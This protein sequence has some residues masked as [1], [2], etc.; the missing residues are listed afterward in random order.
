MLLGVRRAR[1]AM[2]GVGF[3]VK[4]RRKL[5]QVAE[6]LLALAHHRLGLLPLHKLA[7]LAGNDSDR[8]HQALVGRAHV[9]RVKRQD[10]DDAPIG[11]H[12]A[13]ER[14]SRAHVLRESRARIGLCVGH[15]ERLA[16]L[17]C[18]ADEA[19]AGNELELAR[20]GDEA[21]GLRRAVAPR[22]LEAHRRARD[23]DR[24]IA[25]GLPALGF[26]DGLQHATQHRRQAVGLGEHT[27]HRVLEAQAL[28]GALVVGDVAADAA[29]AAEAA[30]G[31]EHR[32]AADRKPA[33]AAVGRR[34]LHLEI[35]ERLVALELRAM[36]LPVG[37]GQVER[38]LVPAAPAE[39]DGSVEAGL[40]GEP[41]RHEGEAKLG[42]LLPVP[43]GRELGEF[44]KAL[45]AAAKRV[46]RARM[47][48][49]EPHRALERAVGELPFEQVVVRAARGRLRAQ[50]RAFIDGERDD[51]IVAGA[52]QRRDRFARRGIGQ[53]QVG[54]DEVV[55]LA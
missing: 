18:R 35:A 31:V 48:R 41:F 24:E 9:A 51:R 46:E 38:R 49:G 19:R 50:L 13:D 2:L 53:V 29:V 26:A 6:A 21:I 28:L 17:P 4:V 33:A 43:V 11:M 40:L 36:P 47:Q 45:L 23:V 7:Y 8:L 42:V 52:N 39:I 1:H 30:F 25:A 12:R 3:P 55:A 16:G 54:N 44:P 34:T 10:A 14:G 37:L 15:P 22:L 20:R 5:D 27:V 32:L